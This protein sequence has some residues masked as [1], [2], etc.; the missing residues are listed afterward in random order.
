MATEEIDGPVGLL[1]TGRAPSALRAEIIE[2]VKAEAPAP[3]LSGYAT[4][5]D[6]QSSELLV[7]T[8]Q[9]LDLGEPLAGRGHAVLAQTQGTVGGYDL[10]AGTVWVFIGDGA[11]WLVFQAGGSGGGGGGVVGSM[12][13]PVLSA[14]NVSHHGARISWGTVKDAASFE[15]RVNGGSIQP[16]TSPWDITGLAMLTPYT[17][18]VRAVGADGSKGAW[19]TVAFRTAETPPTPLTFHKSSAAGYTFPADGSLAISST[20]APDDTAT[21]T[22]FNNTGSGARA[23]ETLV[24]QGFVE[25]TASKAE[26]V[27][28]RAFLVSTTSNAAPIGI[29]LTPSGQINLGGGAYAGGVDSKSTL[30]AGDRFRLGRSADAYYIDQKQGDTWVRLGAQ[31]VGESFPLRFQANN[32]GGSSSFKVTSIAGAGWS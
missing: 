28:Y 19:G 25:F 26:G 8:G 29:F 9:T 31:P 1:P 2:L 16:V 20:N 15:G 14:S 27:Q 18:E 24:G 22:S 30:A 13:A 6:L 4:K 32:W 3:D 5:A 17:V 10:P 23:K 11:K 21:A 7:Y 12:G